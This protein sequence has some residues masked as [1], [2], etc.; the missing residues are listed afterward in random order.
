[1]TIKA[2]N[3]LLVPNAA[4]G[5]EV[6][7][8]ASLE[9]QGLKMKPELGPVVRL[10][11]SQGPFCLALTLTQQDAYALALLI[12]HQCGH[13]DEEG[14]KAAAVRVAHAAQV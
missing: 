10:K 1:M 4:S 11:M 9:Q 2:K 8:L 3:M 6:L 13:L 5:D 12:A 14:G 7:I